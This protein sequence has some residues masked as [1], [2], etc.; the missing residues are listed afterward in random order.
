MGLWTLSTDNL[1]VPST[2]TTPRELEGVAQ[3]GKGGAVLSDVALTL[4]GNNPHARAGGAAVLRH[5]ER[6]ALLISLGSGRWSRWWLSERGAQFL[7]HL[8]PAGAVVR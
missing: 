3:G 4:W 2:E 1:C 8:P 7:K 5:L 6:K